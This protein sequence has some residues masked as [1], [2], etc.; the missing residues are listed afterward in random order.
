VAKV[1][2]YKLE[3]PYKRSVGPVN[4]AFLSGLRDRKILAKAPEGH[5]NSLV[6]GLA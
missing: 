4:S 5:P 6:R 2:T 3:F 1:P